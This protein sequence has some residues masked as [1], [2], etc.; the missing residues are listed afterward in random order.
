MKKVLII[1]GEPSADLHGANLVKAIKSQLLKDKSPTQASLGYPAPFT[2]RGIGGITTGEGAG[3]NKNED[4][5]FIGIGGMLMQQAGVRIIFDA[6]RIAVVG[7]SEVIRHL[8]MINRAFKTAVRTAY[9]EHVDLGILIDFPDFNLRLAKKLYEKGIPLVYYISPQVWAWRKSRIKKIAKY[10]KQVLVIFKFEEDIYREAGI[11]V[12]FVGHPLIKEVKMS[13]SRPNLLKKYGVP[14][15][16]RVIAML[17]G[18]RAS[19]V[20]RHL[21][22]M[23][24]TAML[25]K[26][27]HKEL[28]FVVPVLASQA[29]MCM[30][31]ISGYDLPIKLIVDDTYNAVGASDFAVVTS[32]TATLETALLGIPMIIIYK[33]SLLSHIIAKMLLSIK[34]IGIVNIATGDDIVPELVQD[35]LS[36]GRLARKIDEYLKDSAAY[37]KMI[38]GYSRLR[39]V[40][41]SMD[42]SRRA[43]QEVISLLRAEV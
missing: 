37:S 8:G 6:D 22:I 9:D 14:V 5:E 26:D 31:V 1:A 4:V 20:R 24:K 34:R 11:N 23:L 42:A 35:D 41:S 16:R 18:S 10:F 27:A 7:V 29:E 25:L 2:K 3:I 15:D 13:D 36:P 38:E 21:P 39:N 17:P 32:G 19:E 12:A 40:L 28:F 43:A 33:V 30:Q